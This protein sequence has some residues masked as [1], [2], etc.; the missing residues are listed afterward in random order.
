MRKNEELEGVTL[1]GNQN[2]EY[3]FEYDKTI[4]ETFETNIL[5]T[6]IG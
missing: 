2:V 6:I 4:L 5:T 1:L 3:K